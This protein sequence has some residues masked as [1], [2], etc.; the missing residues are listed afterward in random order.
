M[1]TTVVCAIPWVGR[2]VDT[3]TIFALEGQLWIL[4]V[5]GG[6]VEPAWMDETLIYPDVWEVFRCD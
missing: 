5:N 4:N 3:Y 6:Q 1:G 2:D